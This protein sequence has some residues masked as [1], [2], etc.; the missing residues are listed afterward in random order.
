MYIK[1]P[2]QKG[3]IHCECTY[4]E[5]YQITP[6]LSWEVLPQNYPHPLHVV[7]LLL[8]GTSFRPVQALT[9]ALHTLLAKAPNACEVCLPL[10]N[11]QKHHQYPNKRTNIINYI[12]MELIKLQWLGGGWK[13][14]YQC[15]LSGWVWLTA[16][17]AATTQQ[18]TFSHSVTQVR[19]S[20][21]CAVLNFEMSL[22]SFLHL[23]LI[24]ICDLW[25]Y[26]FT[27]AYVY[28]SVST[29]DECWVATREDIPHS[30]LSFMWS[31]KI[32]A[33]FEIIGPQGD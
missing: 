19:V 3:S 32:P 20:C 13:I 29:R 7:L 4:K 5:V 15:I 23:G 24:L 22:L 1:H 14:Q 12:L 2:T 26:D 28:V 8:L 30:S 27:E 9:E 11:I 31:D 21:D 16:S 10:E 17:V 18:W 33:Y 25:H 6:P